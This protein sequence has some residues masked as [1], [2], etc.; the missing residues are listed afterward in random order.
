M[1]RNESGEQSRAE[2]IMPQGV[3]P[4]RRGYTHSHL[5]ILPASNLK[6]ENKGE[7]VDPIFSNSSGERCAEAQRTF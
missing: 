3:M 6:A 2:S 1:V 7:S 4:S 5:A